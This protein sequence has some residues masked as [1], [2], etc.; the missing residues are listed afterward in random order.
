MMMVL[1]RATIALMVLFPGHGRVM[2]LQAAGFREFAAAVGRPAIQ[3]KHAGI[4]AGEHAKNHEQGE[5]EPH[6]RAAGSAPCAASSSG[7]S[8]ALPWPLPAASVRAA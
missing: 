7:N 6:L 8:R 1:H 3:G 2:D 4:Q 5:Q